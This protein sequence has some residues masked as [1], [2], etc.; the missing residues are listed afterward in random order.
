MP[1]TRAQT[2]I[3]LAQFAASGGLDMPPGATLDEAVA[4]LKSVRGIGDWTANY[5]ALRALRFPDAFPAG[6]LGLQK[7]AAEDGGRLNE[8]QL[9]ARAAGW[10]PWRGYA[11][12]SLWMEM[13]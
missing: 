11:A 13:S 9:L 2:I 3:N 12:L 6:D 5:I 10:S 8:K 4:R 1:G 7:A